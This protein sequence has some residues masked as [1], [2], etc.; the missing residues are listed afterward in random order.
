MIPEHARLEAVLRD[1]NKPPHGRGCPCFDCVQAFGSALPT[2]YL[3]HRPFET[4]Q[5]QPDT[6]ERKRLEI[7]TIPFA[8]PEKRDA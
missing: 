4:Y 5:P 1:L 6:A 8:L 7:Q 3:N 2:S